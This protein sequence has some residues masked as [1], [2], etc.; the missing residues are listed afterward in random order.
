LFAFEAQQQ[1]QGTKSL[2]SPSQTSVAE[3]NNK[4][5]ASPSQKLS[6]RG[7]QQAGGTHTSQAQW[8]R[9]AHQWV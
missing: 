4:P 1:T 3:A 7:Q 5:L 2:A 6:G 8:Q 9:T